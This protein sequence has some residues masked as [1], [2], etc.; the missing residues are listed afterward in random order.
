VTDAIDTFPY[1]TGSVVGV[2]TDEAA[3]EDARRRLDESGFG[4]ERSD[5]LHGQEG[6]ARLDVDGEAHGRSG[7]FKR[8]LQHLFSDGVAVG[9]DAAAKERAAS[10]LHAANAETVNYYV[11]DLDASV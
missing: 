11:E 6:L 2:L 8:W 1:P 4:A 9:D 5:V 3:F 10:A 7:S